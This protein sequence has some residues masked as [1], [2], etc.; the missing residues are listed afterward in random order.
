M[1]TNPNR[2]KFGT[3]P[4][5]LSAEEE[6]RA[7]RLH[8]ESIVIDML[9]WGPC[10]YLSYTEEMENELH[11]NLERYGD[12]GK[13]TVL[14]YFQP[15]RMAV[16]G[17]LPEFKILWDASGITA[18][19]K[20][21]DGFTSM[22]FLSLYFGENITMLDHLPW[23]IKALKAEDIRR[24]KSVGKHAAWINTQL[25]AG[26]GLNFIDL[27]EPA[28]NLGLRMVML[29]Y[30]ST[31]RI[32]SGCT[33]PNDTGLSDFGVNVVACMN[34]LGI[35]VDT[36]HC[37][38]QT[39]L[40]TCRLSTKPVVASHT[41]AQGVYV[42]DRGKGDDELRAVAETDGVIGVYT[43]PYFLSPD[44]GVGMEAMMDHIDYI[45]NL[46]GWEHVGIGTD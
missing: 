29:T 9:Y 13:M 33:E 1:K 24:A 14:S 44:A 39:T 46:V 4:Y 43:V 25:A 19:N 15:Q 41:S 27:L 34:D 6:E 31:T 11:E 5:A 16:R 42:H 38:R 10:T 8:S 22:E 21:V 7:A 26:V 3:Y 36:A 37:G 40:D 32:G 2:L 35:I 30:N 18:G 45:C 12:V 20:M 17:E 28:Y 23:L